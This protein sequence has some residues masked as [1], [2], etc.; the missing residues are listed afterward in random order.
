MGRQEAGSVLLGPWSSVLKGELSDGTPTVGV[1]PEVQEVREV[2]AT[3][4]QGFT[5]GCRC[6]GKEVAF[7]KESLHAFGG[8]VGV[9]DVGS[10]CPLKKKKIYI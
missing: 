3:S 7:H 6:L 9:L 8:G 2:R 10:C 5:S 1:L 4:I